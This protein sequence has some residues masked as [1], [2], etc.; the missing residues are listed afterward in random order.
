M[1]RYVRSGGALG[2]LLLVVVLALGIFVMH[3]TGHPDSASGTAMGAS[4]HAPATTAHTDDST[5][6]TQ[7]VTVSS[8]SS[9]S[10]QDIEASSHA[11]AMGTDM[12]SLCVAV[13]G[14]WI[15]AGLL[16]AA[17]SRRTDWPARLRDGA[18]GTLRP[19]PPPPR[20]SDLARLSV[21]RI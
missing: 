14:T 16:W 6:S 11:P 17:V 7:A 10:A 21:L 13:L 15:L 3:T 9:A 19:D 1:S 2:H 12:A 5:T 20:P 8:H 18:A 4:S